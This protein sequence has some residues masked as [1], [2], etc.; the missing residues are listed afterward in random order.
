MPRTHKIT[1][2]GVQETQRIHEV[3]MIHKT[4]QCCCPKQSRPRFFDSESCWRQ[5]F[6]S[7]AV[8][9]LMSVQALQDILSELQAAKVCVDV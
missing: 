6:K 4:Q 1:S 7:S 3:D 5:E 9:A 8:Y 2:V